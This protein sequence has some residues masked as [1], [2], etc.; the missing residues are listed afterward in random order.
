[1][2]QNVQ[3]K[4]LNK[5]VIV[6][7]AIFASF[8]LISLFRSILTQEKPHFDIPQTENKEIYLDYAG[9]AV[10]KNEQIDKFS[11]LL[12]NHF[13]CNTHS[14][15]VCGLRSAEELR[16]ARKLVLDFFSASNYEVVFTSGC[17]AALRLIG[18]SYPFTN[19]SSF[20]FTE[21]NHNSVLGIREFAKL[22]GASFQSYSTFDDIETKVK[23]N[24]QTLFAYPAEN[25]FDGEQYPLEWI[26][27][28]ERHANWNCVLD[29]A[30]Y[31]SHS[32][33]N[34]TQHTPSFVTLSFYKIFGFPTGI[35]ALLVR[36]DV[37]TKLSPI[38]FGGGTVYS[39]LPQTDY[40]IFYSKAP[41]LEAGSLSIQTIVALQFGFEMIAKIGVTNIQKT[42]TVL[43][44]RLA[45]T[46]HS[47]KHQNGKNVFEIYGNFFTTKLQGPTVT[48]NVFNEKGEMYPTAKL[49]AFLREKKINVRT[50]CM[51]NPGSCLSAVGID[52]Q[53]YMSHMTG[54]QT[55]GLDPES[56][57]D[58]V[59]GNKEAGAVRVSLGYATTQ[60]DIVVLVNALQEFLQSNG[61]VGDIHLD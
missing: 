58:I 53:D 59:I 47:T 49:N 26:D 23:T 10:Y 14:P 29:A 34:L 21:Q 32:P 50:G 56:C 3:R 46:L 38:Y 43:A 35:G 18:E 15:N 9:A 20:I 60:N 22:R 25:N 31:V 30:A 39:S 33:L 24:T 36:K 42:T 52:I 57:L 16:K 28:I 4:D 44:T 8:C 1:M 55:D 54:I 41:K 61:W 6:T 12:K 40:K 19:S 2:N 7:I 27:Q 5:I 37:I 45:H 17:T 48:F 13:Y 51:C 11:N